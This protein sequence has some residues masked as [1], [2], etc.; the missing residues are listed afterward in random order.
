MGLGDPFSSI[1]HMVGGALGIVGLVLLVVWADGPME[2]VS[3]AVYGTSLVALYTLSAI[4]HAFPHRNQARPWLRRMDHVGI[5]F[6]IAGTYTPVVL[7]TLGGGWGWSLFGVVW[8]L[9]ILGMVLKL[10]LPM[11]PRWITTVSYVGLG[12]LAL[13]AIPVMWDALPPAGL[14]WLLAGGITYTAGAL[15]YYLNKQNRVWGLD[16]H[17]LWHLFV[18]GGSAAHWVL[19]FAY[20]L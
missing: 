11:A 17:D 8:G 5:Y 2:I 20:V 3:A 1:S 18:L 7:V 12:W 14:G 16:G 9:A 4:Y 6:L 10:T 15:V 19:V 13:V